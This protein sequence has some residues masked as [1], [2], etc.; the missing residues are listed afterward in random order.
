MTAAVGL[1]ALLVVALLIAG[2]QPPVTSPPTPLL[3]G[4]MRPHSVAVNSEGEWTGQALSLQFATNTP[5]PT[6]DCTINGAPC[7][8]VRAALEARDMAVPQGISFV[9][10]T[11]YPT[12]YPTATITPTARPELV[13][14]WTCYEYERG[15]ME[16]VGR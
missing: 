15:V 6:V 16:C 11:A 8:S 14:I 3:S 9:T 5:R 10:A 1:G 7:A 2:W 4:D 13:R 12:S